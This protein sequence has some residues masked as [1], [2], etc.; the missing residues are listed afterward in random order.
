[1]IIPIINKLFQRIEKEGK[2]LI[3]FYEAVTTLLPKS[4]KDYMRKKNY[5]LVSSLFTGVDTLKTL[6]NQI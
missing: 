3:L 4:D 6:A 5:R 2:V 1:M